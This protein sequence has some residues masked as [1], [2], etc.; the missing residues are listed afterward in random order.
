MLTAKIQCCTAL[1]LLLL[2]TCLGYLNNHTFVF[3]SGWPQSGKPIALISPN[4][5]LQPSLFTG[6]SF[7]NQILS[8]APNVSTMVKKCDE[9]VGAKCINWNHEG[10][11]LLKASTYLSKVYNPGSICPCQEIASDELKQSIQLQWKSFWSMDQTVLVEKSPQNLLKMPFLKNVFS[12]AKKIKFI[13]VIKHPVTLNI[14]TP[15]DMKWLSHAVKSGSKQ[16]TNGIHKT[17]RDTR[18]SPNQIN[19]NIRHFIDFLTHNRSIDGRDCSLGWLPAMNMFRKYL[20]HEINSTL[21]EVRILRYEDF[22][23][24]HTLCKAIFSFIFDSHDNDAYNAAILRV[25]DVHFPPSL[26]RTLELNKRSHAQQAQSQ[27]PGTKARSRLRG[28]QLPSNQ[29]T[30]RRQLDQVERHDA[31]GNVTH[32]FLISLLQSES[33]DNSARRSLRLKI[34]KENVGVGGA[35]K[36]NA[37]TLNFRPEV[38]AESGLK[39]FAEYQEA[40]GVAKP[41]L[42]KTLDLLDKRLAPI[43]YNLKTLH[44]YRHETT[45]F[46]P[47]D[48]MKLFLKGKH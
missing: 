17:V 29:G 15:K 10:Q 23:A 35:P 42:K 45:I 44:G 19:E 1:L 33:A 28:P 11:W 39:R 3:V 5:F 6:T 7:L 47:W 24:A 40:Y 43:G 41:E 37:L 2:A 12:E 20:A 30:E 32:H 4:S 18:N 46:D 8:I 16:L 38:V 34:E 31:S 13:V 21:L 14:A 26:S 22:Q 36:S 25:C 27:A 9:I 48:I